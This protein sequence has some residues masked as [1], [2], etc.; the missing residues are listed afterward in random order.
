MSIKSEIDRIKAAIAAAYQAV[1]NKGGT[2][3]AAD[4]AANL[5]Q[6]IGTIPSGITPTGTL[7]IVANQNGIDVAQYAL[8][9]VD[10]PPPAG[11]AD[12]S[13]VTAG[14]GDVLAP[15]YIVNSSGVRTQGTMQNVTA[16]IRISARDDNIPIPQ[17]YH[18]GT[19]N[20]RLASAERDKLIAENIRKDITLLGIPGG[21]SGFT[22]M[23]T[24]T[25]TNSSVITTSNYSNSANM[26]NTGI[27][28]PRV[29]IVTRN[30]YDSTGL[31]KA[32]TH[33]LVESYYLT[34][35][36]NP[37]GNSSGY[38]GRATVL[39]NNGTVRASTSIY[40]GPAASGSS[41]I[42]CTLASGY[43]APIQEWRWVAFA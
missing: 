19:S 13:G 32:S 22:Q 39:F 40:W 42:R 4:T 31:S 26:I 34:A 16:N 28:D 21:F 41:Y 7:Q 8:A 15:K 33:Q 35:D 36:T 24:G 23:K 27:V 11:W 20:V 6:A 10:V 2:V 30:A 12:V 3:P 38:R 29:I 25:W 17:G 1:G 37:E 14:A 18:A 9:D 5:A 43:T